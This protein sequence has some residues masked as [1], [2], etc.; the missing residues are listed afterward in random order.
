MGQAEV[1]AY[2]SNQSLTL[3]DRLADEA[4]LMRWNSQGGTDWPLK[5]MGRALRAPRG[6]EET[7]SKASQ[8][9]S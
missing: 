4:Q 8:R 9:T 5:M 1:A 7:N 3:P 2:G 6:I